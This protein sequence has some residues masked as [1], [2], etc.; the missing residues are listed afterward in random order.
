E[1]LESGEKYEAK[2]T[3]AVKTGGFKIKY[4]RNEGKKCDSIKYTYKAQD[5]IPSVP[6]Y[7]DYH[8]GKRIIDK[9]NRI[10][11]IKVIFKNGVMRAHNPN[12]PPTYFDIN[13]DKNISPEVDNLGWLN[14]KAK[15]YLGGMKK[16]HD[17]DGLFEN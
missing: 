10:Y 9:N 4:L 8:T 17:V 11:K 3:K 2:V 6:S 13:S 5:L 12:F 1:R 16:A 14:K 7:K 15:F